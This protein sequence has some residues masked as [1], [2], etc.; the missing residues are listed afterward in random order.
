[1]SLLTEIRGDTHTHTHTPR[2]MEKHKWI[3]RIDITLG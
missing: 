3:H 1:M 2:Q